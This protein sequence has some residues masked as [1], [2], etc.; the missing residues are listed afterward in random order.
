MTESGDHGSLTGRDDLRILLELLSSYVLNL[1]LLSDLVLN[2]NDVDTVFGPSD[3]NG[4]WRGRNGLLLNLG[5]FARGRHTCPRV[6]L[7]LGGALRLDVARGGDWSM[8]LN[9]GNISLT[10]TTLQSI[11]LCWWVLL[12]RLDGLVGSLAEPADLSLHLKLVPFLCSQ[13]LILACVH[14]VSCFRPP[15]H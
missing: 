7:S 14:Q 2:L 6:L 10:A 12:R 15:I 13:V 1:L 8:T 3:L 9:C 11:P 5:D 4:L